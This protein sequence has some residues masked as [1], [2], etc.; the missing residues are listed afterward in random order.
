MRPSLRNPNQLRDIKITRHYTK[1]AEGSVLIEVGHTKVICN[2]SIIKG[3]PKFLKEQKPGSGWL[4]AEYSLLPRA[5]N[6]RTDRE[7]VRG[8]QSGRTQEIQ[9][10][11]GRALRS[12]LDLMLLGEWTVML[13]CDV[14]QADGGTRTAAITGSSVALADAIRHLYLQNL[15]KQNPL[16]HLIAAISV[17]IYEGIPILDLDYAEDSKAETDM[18]VV[19]NDNEGIIEIQGTAEGRAFS[20]DEFHQMMNLAKNGITQIILLQ[21]KALELK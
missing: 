21:K 6:E 11:I 2:A 17:G 8:K 3:V 9:R 1:F 10:L 14:L 12:S 19:M 5:T 15:I 7:A 18:N 4:T 20:E 13:D 16:K